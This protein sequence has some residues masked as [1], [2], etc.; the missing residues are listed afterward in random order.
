MSK[1]V[2]QYD[3]M[4]LDSEV[5]LHESEAIARVKKIEIKCPVTVYLRPSSPS[6]V[7]LKSKIPMDL[8]INAFQGTDYVKDISSFT[9]DSN[10]INGFWIRSKLTSS[11]CEID[12]TWQPSSE[13][14]NGFGGKTT[15]LDSLIFHLFD[16]IELRGT[17]VTTEVDGS[18]SKAIPH[19][20]LEFDSWH[21]ELK[22]IAS[23]LDLNQ[24]EKWKKGFQL[25]HVGK[26]R[27]LSGESFTWNECKTIIDSLRFFLSFCRGG[28]CSPVCFVGYD[29]CGSRVF[30]SWS[31]PD[32]IRHSPHHWVDRHH[33]TQMSSFYPLYMKAWITKNWSKTF[34]E[35]FYWYVRANNASQGIDAGIILTQAGLER[36][37]YEYVVVKKKLLLTKGFKDLWASDKF[38]IL[39]SSVEIPLGIP[40]ECENMLKL[41]KSYN[42]IDAPHALTEIRNSLIHPENT[43][44]GKFTSAY[45]EAWNLGLWYLEMGIL[46]ICGYKGGYSNRLKNH[47]VGEIE[48]V[49]WS[50]DK[51]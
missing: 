23:T 17:R 35:V 44:K 51:P 19:L 8:N 43:K 10:E 27:K 28:W 34:T 42:W 49:P 20:D 37:S 13:P 46:A 48:K 4:S 25:T 7:L 39:F 50:T 31:S 47:W 18:I 22:L 40:N 5:K 14:I 30:E 29:I 2:P 6:S 16:F 45:H 26:I 41:A 1:L 3:F 12:L 9:L 11:R 24:N 36:L 15:E 21:I 32:E 38:R 33:G